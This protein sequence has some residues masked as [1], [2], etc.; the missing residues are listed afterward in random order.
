MVGT[1]TVER[2]LNGRG[3]VRPDTV[4]KVLSA[5]RVLDWPG[6]L[7]DQHR[8]ILRIEIILVRPDTTFYSRVAAAFRRIMKSLDKSLQIQLTFIDENDPRA[9]ADRI[10][11][12]AAR[13]SGLIIVCPA[14]KEVANALK[15]LGRAGVPIIQIV[16]R[17]VEDLDFVGIDNV[18]AGRVAA[19]MVS[20][21]GHVRGS[22]VALCHSQ[23]YGIHRE[24]IRG[25]SDYFRDFPNDAID[26]KM[27]TFGRDDHRI[28][29]ER[30]SEALKD[31]SLV[32]IYNAGGAN[33]AVLRELL[34]SRRDIFFVGHELTEN[35]R[36]ALIEGTA[37]VILDQDPEAQARRA[38][39]IMLSK[40]GMLAE[41]IE[42]PPVR[43]IIVTSENL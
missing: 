31:P 5:S 21:L 25:F 13:R 39:D 1:A 15:K 23:A 6:R 30:I 37:D 4:E 11:H 7:P 28:S 34:S 29:A 26:F 43:F 33:S 24:R 27:V 19:M 32:A 12:P 22:V 16:S 36:L 41:K 38:I 35:S 17:T 3:G 18:A 42:N 2:V 9:I 14:Y 20:R 40:I 8:G 10:L